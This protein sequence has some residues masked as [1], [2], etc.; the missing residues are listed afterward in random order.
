MKSGRERGGASSCAYAWLGDFLVVRECAGKCESSRVADDSYC[1]VVRSIAAVI[2]C[3]L[4][5]W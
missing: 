1:S 3:I 5:D 4:N 2:N